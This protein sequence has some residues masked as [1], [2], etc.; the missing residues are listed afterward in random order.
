MQKDPCMTDNLEKARKLLRKLDKSEIITLST[1]CRD[2]TEP[3]FSGRLDQGEADLIHDVASYVIRVE[4]GKEIKRLEQE[5]GF[6]DAG[7]D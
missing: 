2:A 1:G 4:Q 6:S 7:K 5:L 3:G